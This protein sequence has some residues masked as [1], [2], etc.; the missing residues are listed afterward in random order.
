MF[1][2]KNNLITKDPEIELLPEYKKTNIRF[3]KQDE[4]SNVRK[5]SHNDL[6]NDNNEN[7]LSDKQLK[8]ISKFFGLGLVKGISDISTSDVNAKVFF[9]WKA[10][11]NN[12]WYW[13]R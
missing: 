10:F 11:N 12:I 4:S 1:N 5:L 2:E 13:F 9:I 3:D 8:I 6:L 7:I